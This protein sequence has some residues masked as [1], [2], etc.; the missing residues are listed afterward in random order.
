MTHQSLKPYC[1]AVVEPSGKYTKFDEVVFCANWPDACHEHIN[2]AIDSGVSASKWVVRELFT[3]PAPT[4]KQSLTVQTGKRKELIERLRHRARYLLSIEV[5]DAFPLLNEAADM[6]EADEQWE[7]LRDPAVLHVNLLRG[8]PAQLTKEHLLH[9]LGDDARVPMTESEIH[10]AVKSVGLDWHRGFAGEDNRYSDLVRV[11]E[12]RH[13][14]TGE[15][16]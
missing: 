5:N 12:V 1:Y 16:K 11:V 9:L 10:T 7:L 8:L 3:H 14:I 6:L 13:G 15:A 2:D 4:I